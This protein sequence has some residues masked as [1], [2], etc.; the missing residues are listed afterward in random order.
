MLEVVGHEMQ[1]Q[2]LLPTELVRELALRAREHDSVGGIADAHLSLSLLTFLS[3][4]VV[5]SAVIGTS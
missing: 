1:L 3:G 2:S 4:C 5:L